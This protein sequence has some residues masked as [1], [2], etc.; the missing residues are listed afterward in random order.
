LLLFNCFIDDTSRTLPSWAATKTNPK[1]KAPKPN[2]MNLETL[3]AWASLIPRPQKGRTKSS[4]Q[5]AAN[6]FKP[7]ETVLYDKSVN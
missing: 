3:V 2:A 1:H 5:M 6:E 7:L 4:K